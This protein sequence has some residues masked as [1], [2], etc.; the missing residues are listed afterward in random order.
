M[1]M[2]AVLESLKALEDMGLSQKKLLLSLD[3][4]Y[5]RKALSDSFFQWDC[6]DQRMERTGLEKV[7]WGSSCQPG[8]VEGN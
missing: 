1:E 7:K 3:S 4:D 2:T 6:L 8:L 5:V